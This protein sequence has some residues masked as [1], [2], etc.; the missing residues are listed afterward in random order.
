MIRVRNSLDGHGLVESV[1]GYGLFRFQLVPNLTKFRQFHFAIMFCF[2]AQITKG[3]KLLPARLIF[4]Y[5][6]LLWGKPGSLLKPVVHKISSV[7]SNLFTFGLVCYFCPTAK[8]STFW[9]PIITK[10]LTR[11]QLILEKNH[12]STFLKRDI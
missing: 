11:R 6:W 8:K 5:I 3:P 12:L 7:E 4:V 2:C 9:L 10:Y 1:L